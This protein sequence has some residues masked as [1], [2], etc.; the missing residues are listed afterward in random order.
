MAKKSNFEPNANVKKLLKRQ[1]FDVCF[2]I[3]TNFEMIRLLLRG[4]TYYIVRIMKSLS[5]A[6]ELERGNLNK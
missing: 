4:Q 5:F 6:E 3:R 1:I 2:D